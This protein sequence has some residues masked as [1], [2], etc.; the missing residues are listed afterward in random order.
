MS[1]D[2]DILMY[3]GYLFSLV[4][5]LN[6]IPIPNVELLFTV[7]KA[8]YEYSNVCKL[9]IIHFVKRLEYRIKRGKSFG[10]QLKLSDMI[11]PKM[12]NYSS[13]E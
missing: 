9:K 12:S 6:H 2:A 5:V 3:I 10:N 1:V 8:C 13:C 4:V 11:E 7:R